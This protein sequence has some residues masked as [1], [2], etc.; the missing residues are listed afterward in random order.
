M[1]APALRFYPPASSQLPAHLHPPLSCEALGAFSTHPSAPF[2]GASSCMQCPSSPRHSRVPRRQGGLLRGA[3]GLRRALEPGL[4]VMHCTDMQGL[5]PRRQEGV[6][7]AHGERPALPGLRPTSL[8]PQNQRKALREAAEREAEQRRGAGRAPQQRGAGG[9]P[10][11][12]GRREGV[13]RGSG[14]LTSTLA[15]AL[16]SHIR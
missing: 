13:Q 3:G 16:S 2:A 1:P 7:G 4:R 9:G 10:E 14:V 12:A 8:V 11:L 15:T 6:S 5:P